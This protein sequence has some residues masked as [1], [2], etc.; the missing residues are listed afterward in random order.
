MVG[1]PRSQGTSC[2]FCDQIPHGL[3]SGLYGS[4]MG[5]HG[6]NMGVHGGLGYRGLAWGCTEWG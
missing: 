4:N 2:M 1:L 6:A 3:R 5:L